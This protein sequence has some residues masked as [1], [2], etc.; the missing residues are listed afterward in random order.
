MA[1]CM[2]VSCAHH[3]CNQ[4]KKLNLFKIISSVLPT[5]YGDCMRKTERTKPKLQHRAVNK[6]QIL[7]KFSVRL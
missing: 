2:C 4:E 3:E 7:N 5:I 1:V 6:N